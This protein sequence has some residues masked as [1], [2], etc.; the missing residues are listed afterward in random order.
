MSYIK[1]HP[2]YLPEILTEI[3]SYLA[4]DRSLYPTL[5]VNKFWYSYAGSIIWRC[6]E[7]DKRNL[8]QFEKFKKVMRGKQKPLYCSKLLQLVLHKCK[9][10]DR[11]LIKIARETPR[12][13]YLVLDECK[14]FSYE[15]TA[16]SL[17]MW[18]NLKHFKFDSNTIKKRVSGVNI[19]ICIDDKILCE[20][21]N[22]NL[23]YLS[24]G[25]SDLSDKSLNKIAD[26]CPNLKYLSL[27]CEENIT[28]VSMIDIAHSCPKLRYLS[29]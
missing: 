7:F 29:L 28:D 16:D 20:I 15:S 18:R 12:L 4:K 27:E 13:E 5:F 14:G 11:A 21:A 10:S 3:F 19:N 22:Q 1:L 2:L 25:S 17:K 24:L 9:I 6:A 8:V 23:E 26:S